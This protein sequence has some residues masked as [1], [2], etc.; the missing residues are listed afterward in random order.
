MGEDHKE[1][2]RTRAIRKNTIIS[3]FHVEF[4]KEKTA[5]RKIVVL[6][7][8][9]RNNPETNKIWVHQIYYIHNI[10]INK[11]KINKIFFTDILSWY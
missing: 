9:H 11:L 4:V 5:W 3:I 1:F 7:E 10:K 6:K 2:L 8:N